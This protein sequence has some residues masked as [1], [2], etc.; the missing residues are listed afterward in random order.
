MS[1]FRVSSSVVCRRGA[2][3]AV[4]IGT[5]G[6]GL[7]KCG[8]GIDALTITGLELGLAETLGGSSDTFRSRMVVLSALIGGST[9]SSGGAAGA[10]LRTNALDMA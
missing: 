6:T 4:K 5:G 7:V 2:T 10:S 1:I 8:L 9:D 3:C